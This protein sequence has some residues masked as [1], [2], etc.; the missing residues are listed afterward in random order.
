MNSVSIK[1][2]R[3]RYYH[4]VR[5]LAVFIIGP[6]LLCKGVNYDDKILLLVG[7][8]LIVWDGIKIYYD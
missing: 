4:K 7:I 2:I 5:I 1:G 8:L 3:E 6:L